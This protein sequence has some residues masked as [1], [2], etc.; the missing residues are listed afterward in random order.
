MEGGKKKESPLEGEA[1]PNILFVRQLHY[2]SDKMR[3]ISD[4]KLLDGL[5]KLRIKS[6]KKGRNVYRATERTV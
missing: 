6:R 4:I 3:S 2:F 1:A 5:D